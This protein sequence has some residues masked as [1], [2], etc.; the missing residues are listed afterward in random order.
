VEQNA[1]VVVN[2]ERYYR[3][4]FKRNENSWNMRD[5]HMVDTLHHVMEHLKSTTGTGKIVVWA[6]NSHLGNAKATE[7][8]MHDITHQHNL[9]NLSYDMLCA[10]VTPAE[11]GEHNVG[12]LMKERWGRDCVNIGFSTYTGTVTAAH[13]WD[14]PAQQKKVKFGLKGSWE[15]L[16]CDATVLTVHVLIIVFRKHFIIQTFRNSFSTFVMREV[17]QE[18]NCSNRVCNEP[19]V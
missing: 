19:L 6:H 1:R 3:E 4:M 16:C 12:Q 15:V 18:L 5:S 9:A 11:R 17:K 7:V 14:E 2:A 8:G 10:H 13:E